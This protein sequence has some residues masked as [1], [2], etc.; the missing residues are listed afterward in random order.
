MTET[1]DAWKSDWR[2]TWDDVRRRVDRFLS[3]LVQQHQNN[4]VVVTHGV[5]I[6]A[7]LRTY[8]PH[9]LGKERRV[10][11]TDAYACQCVSSNGTFSRIQQVR[12]IVDGGSINNR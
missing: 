9:V 5:W 4:V 6:E 12:Q 7:L 3:W 8:A 11:N 2:E 10:Y 1:D